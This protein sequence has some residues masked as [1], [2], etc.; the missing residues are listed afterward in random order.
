VAPLAGQLGTPV[1]GIIPDAI[2]NK[3]GALTDEEWREMREHPRMTA[4]Q[5]A[6]RATMNR[7]T[8]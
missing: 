8:P 7:S 5:D 3:P 1:V 4:E 6:M 2:L